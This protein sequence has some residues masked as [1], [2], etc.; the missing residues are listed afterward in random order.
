[1]EGGR[2]LEEGQKYRERGTPDSPV[3]HDFL[4]GAVITNNIQGNLNL[5]DSLDKYNDYSSTMYT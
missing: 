1:M 2:M 4:S 5:L 3:K